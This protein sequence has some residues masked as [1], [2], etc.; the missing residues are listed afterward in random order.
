MKKMEE[1]V[2]Q[3]LIDEQN[4]KLNIANEEVLEESFEEEESEEDYEEESEGEEEENKV[5]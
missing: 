5:Y 2:Q 3:Q 4:Q 1:E